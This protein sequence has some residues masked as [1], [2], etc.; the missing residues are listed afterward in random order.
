MATSLADAGIQGRTD[1]GIYIYIGV[2]SAVLNTVL[3]VAPVIA[4]K[5]VE[6]FGVTPIELGSLFSLELASFSLAS[7]PAYLWMRRL[8]LRTATYLFTSI[9]VAGNIASG[10][11]DSFA[12]L[13]GARFITSL[14]SGSIM[15]ILLALSGKASN[16][17]RAFGVFV[18]SQLAMG[19]L[20]LA[21][22]PLVF[23]S[24]GVEAIYWTLAAL[25]ALCLLAV[26]CIDGDALRPSPLTA[27]DGEQADAGPAKTK[28]PA[29]LLALG[30]AAVLLFY[31]ALSSVWTFIAQISA[32][33]GIGLSA[34]SLVLSLATVAGILSASVAT[35]LG[36]SPRRKVFL[37]IGYLGMG[38]SVAL[39][40]GT[41]GLIRFA[42]AAVIFK[43]AW[44]FILPYLLSTLSDLGSGN[45]MI[46]VNLVIGTG[47]AIG[48]M[49]GGA[50]VQSTGGFNALVAVAL[51][52]LLLS[53]AAV[54]AI[55]RRRA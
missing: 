22:F 24:A 47:F 14:A 25:A 3:L 16:P 9:V 54:A 8:N 5:L 49:L 26:R 53:M 33:S 35:I 42:T 27:D 11:M 32:A 43:F 37:L 40:F 48:P 41:P 51:V 50:L 12:S 44:T 46:A 29:V 38:L 4:G 17:S 23:A 15:V 36:E 39:L 34:S 6:R 45:I 31:V 28:A 2:F 19:A 1:R 20:I 13:M 55:Q 21:L 7:L 52:G 18:V 30:L 10:F